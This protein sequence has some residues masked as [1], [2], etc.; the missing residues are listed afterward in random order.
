MAPF[1]KPHQEATPGKK[2]RSTSSVEEDGSP[3]ACRRLSFK[4]SFLSYVK[5]NV[6][7]ALPASHPPGH[8]WPPAPHLV[9]DTISPH[10]PPHSPYCSLT[11]LAAGQGRGGEEGTPSLGPAELVLSISWSLLEGH[12]LCKPYLT[13]SPQ[14]LTPPG[15]SLFLPPL[16][17][18]HCHSLTLEG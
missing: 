2:E 7:T 12:Q 5:A 3:S 15:C 16:Q 17:A 9:P 8:I 13:F 4:G 10:S 6:T 1:S 11:G 14:W 18:A